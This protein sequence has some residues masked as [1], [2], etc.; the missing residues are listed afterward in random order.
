MYRMLFHR[1]KSVT[2]RTG[3]IEEQTQ[4]IGRDLL[5]RARG[6]TRGFFSSR[7]WSDKLMEWATKD[8]AFKV[9][10]F[11]FVDVFPMLKDPAQIH[12][13][14]LQYFSQPGVTLPAGM[15][16]GMK[17]GGVFQGTL[18]NTIASQIHAMAEKF[19]AGADA[20]SALPRLRELWDRGMAFSV[21]L[22]G[23]ACVSD[24]EAIAYQNRYLD[25]IQNL[26][27][28]VAYWP[29]HPLLESDHLGSIPRCNVS[30][31]ISSLHA[32][33]KAIDTEG[34]VRRLLEALR[35]VLE[36]A[37]QNNVLI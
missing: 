4:Q 27:K 29:S 18:A 22:L 28:Q 34:S 24:V 30:L 36:A 37:K 17:A 16:L 12:E 31:K 20:A 10:L 25:L 11:R 21:D 6:H 3:S 8:P 2:P 9:Q 15:S 1:A 5:E 32:R 33:T 19:I 23:E 35:P 26:S 13:H 14:L 7:F